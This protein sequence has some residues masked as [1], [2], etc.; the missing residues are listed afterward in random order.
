MCNRFRT[1]RAAKR[2]FNATNLQQPGTYIQQS[3]SGRSLRKNSRSSKQKRTECTDELA[4]IHNQQNRNRTSTMRPIEKEHC[5]KFS[6]QII[7]SKVHHDKWFIRAS[8]N[9]TNIH[10]S[11]LPIFSNHIDTSISHL[12]SDEMKYLTE[13]TKENIPAISVSKLLLKNTI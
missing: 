13:L 4:I 8:N 5:C 10:T 6:L 9:T 3:H 1:S 12:G 11:H 2:K 7:C